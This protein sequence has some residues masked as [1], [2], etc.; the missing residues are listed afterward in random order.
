MWLL[1]LPHIISSLEQLDVPVVDRAICERLFGIRR[2]RAI[3]LLEMFGG[4]QVGRTYLVNRTDLIDQLRTLVTGPVFERERSRKRKLTSSLDE[5]HRRRAAAH[6]RIPVAPIG[7]DRG[8]GLPDGIVMAP[9]I[10]SV[11]YITTEHLLSRLF[12]LAVWAADD[13][14][15]FCAVM[16]PTRHDG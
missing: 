9:G 16:E 3:T 15:S 2:R 10:L 7:T 8:P 11:A 6:V 12:A 1:R 5:L 13:Y 4:Y 14:D